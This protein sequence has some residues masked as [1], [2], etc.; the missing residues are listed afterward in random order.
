MYTWDIHLLY[1]SVIQMFSSF[2][3]TSLMVMFSNNSFSTYQKKLGQGNNSTVFTNTL[4]QGIQCHLHS[5]LLWVSWT[6]SY[7][8][9]IHKHI[10][11]AEKYHIAYAFTN[12]LGDMALKCILHVYH[13]CTISTTKKNTNICVQYQCNFFSLEP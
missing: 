4:G 10:G 11:S 1:T 5:Q 3:E 12:S 13:T 7:T 8:C 6:I 2:S 9:S